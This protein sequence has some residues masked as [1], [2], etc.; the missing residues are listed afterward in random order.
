MIQ[1]EEFANLLSGI[2]Q[3]VTLSLRIQQYTSQWKSYLRKYSPE[4]VPSN[5]FRVDN[6]LKLNL[7]EDNFSGEYFRRERFHRKV[8]YSIRK[9]MGQ[10][11]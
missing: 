8:Y 7:F 6:I 11:A 2:M 10:I 4:K 3:Y 9:A 5:K 1:S